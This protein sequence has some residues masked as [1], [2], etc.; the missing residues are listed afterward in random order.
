MRY[1]KQRNISWLKSTNTCYW[2]LVPWASHNSAGELNSRLHLLFQDCSAWVPFRTRLRK[3]PSSG[4]WGV[5]FPRVE[6]RSAEMDS[7]KWWFLV[8]WLRA[9]QGLCHCFSNGQAHRGMGTPSLLTMSQ[10]KG[11]KE[12]KDVGKQCN[13]FHIWT[14]TISWWIGL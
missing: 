8:L 6:L 12:E 1:G 13:C 11:G 4:A 2:Q 5:G 7:S 10:G 14:F 3:Q 9:G